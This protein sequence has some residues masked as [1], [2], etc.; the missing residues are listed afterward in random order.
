[1]DNYYII[2]GGPGAGK[3]TLIAALASAGFATASESGR[4]ILTHQQ[5]IDGP[6]QHTRDAALYAEIMLQRD[7]ESHGAL[8]GAAGPAFFDR[9]VP[10][11]VGYLEM[12]GHSVPPHFKRA[13]ARYRY[14]DTVFLAP[15][16]PEIYAHDELRKQSPDEAQRS[17]DVAAAIYPRFGYRTLE[18]PRASVGERV[19]F[20]RAAIGLS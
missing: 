16:W 12:M 5:A 4:A 20:V 2:S 14:N 9:G 1:M 8:R 17:Y 18:L 3:T 6:A 7:M 13:A 15:P 11:L 19:A 10:E